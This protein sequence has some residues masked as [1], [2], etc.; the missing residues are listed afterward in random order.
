MR[1]FKILFNIFKLACVIC[2]LPIVLFTGA[3]VNLAKLFFGDKTKNNGQSTTSRSSA[4]DEKVQA[5]NLKRQLEVFELYDHPSDAQREFL[6]QIGLKPFV[7][8]VRKWHRSK[9]M[10]KYVE[11]HFKDE[12]F[13][14]KV[15]IVKQTG[16]R[17]QKEKKIW[18]LA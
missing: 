13:K 5:N 11:I 17:F 7:N 18:A 8:D 3:E 2:L 4:S 16:Y 1:L 14:W 10:A 6:N 9:S 15:A 12:L